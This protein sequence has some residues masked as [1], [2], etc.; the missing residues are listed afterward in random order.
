MQER[1]AW[2]PTS[3]VQAPQRPMPQP[4]L[5]PLRFNTSRSTHKRGI[6]GD[7][8]TVPA[9]LLTFNLIDICSLR[10][11]VRGRGSVTHSGIECIKFP[12]LDSNNYRELWLSLT[13][14][15]RRFISNAFV[16]PRCPAGSHERPELAWLQCL[17]EREG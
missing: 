2:P 10:N 12:L 17:P 15:A 1:T 7:T 3:T 4:Y 8:S 6:S 11:P 9:T 13:G 14:N 5:E 16:A